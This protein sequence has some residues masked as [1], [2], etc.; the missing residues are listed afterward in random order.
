MLG[1]DR[2]ATIDGERLQLLVR[3]PAIERRVLAFAE[4]VYSDVAIN[5]PAPAPQLAPER[6]R[7]P[8][9][10]RPAVTSAPSAPRIPTLPTTGPGRQ[11]ELVAALQ[12]LL[13]VARGRN[14]VAHA[15]LLRIEL[16][17]HQASDLLMQGLVP[18]VTLR[19]IDGQETWLV[20][21]SDP[22]GI[23]EILKDAGYAAATSTRTP[24]GSTDVV[25]ALAVDP[26]TVASVAASLDTTPESDVVD[27]IQIERS[28]EPDRDQD[29]DP[30]RADE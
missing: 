19:H 20:H 25:E 12:Q 27:E 10:A 18:T 4:A 22:D 14:L 29:V 28:A 15:P 8:P 11:R 6:P 13:P 2:V 3:D 30:D 21:A 26:W 9:L 5:R 1:R 7:T 16:A 24:I 17:P 23:A